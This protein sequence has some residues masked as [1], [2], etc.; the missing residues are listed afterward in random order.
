MEN[1]LRDFIYTIANDAKS[2]GNVL[3]EFLD[4]PIDLSVIGI[5]YASKVSDILVGPLLFTLIGLGIVK[6][7]VDVVIP[8]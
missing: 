5:D 6:W 3:F 7:I 4:T 1:V 2:L 8:N